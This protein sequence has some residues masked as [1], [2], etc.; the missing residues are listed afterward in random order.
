MSLIIG[1]SRSM[2]AAVCG[3]VRDLLFPRGCAGCDLPDEVLCPSCS[4]LFMER[5]EFPVAGLFHGPGLACA[6]YR[7]PARRAILGW[8]DH[9]DQELT[10]PLSEALSHLALDAGQVFGAPMG[11]ILVVPAPSSAASM[12]RRGRMHMLP[13]ARAV[14]AAFTKAGRP[15][16][17][18]PA[19]VMEAVRGK[20][21]ELH[22]STAR[23][24]R[25][26][27]RIHVKRGSGVDGR[28]VIVVDDIVT[29]GS[30]VRQCILA[31]RAANAKPL[32]V[33]A[34]AL[35]GP[36]QGA[37]AGPVRSYGMNRGHLVPTGCAAR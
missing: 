11:P 21:V 9:D 8:K 25:L 30:T 26:S 27:G 24:G 34:L 22:G 5:Y 18:C 36:E 4:A 32:A 23:A 37:D 33:L 28:S 20:A 16:R 2:L 35:A 7:G 6:K 17:A 3:E 19:L 15:A 31:L 1:L 10:G 12:R 14:A 13:L 29:T